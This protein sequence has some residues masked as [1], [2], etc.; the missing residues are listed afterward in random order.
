MVLAIMGLL[1]GGFLL[2]FGTWLDN[3]RVKDT[4]R[5]L[6]AVQEAL[7]GFAITA[8]VPRLPCPDTD[9]DGLED[10]A[11]DGSCLQTEGALPW[12]SLGLTR[13][14][15][16]GRPFRYAPDDAYAAA[17]GIPARP[18]T[19]TGFVVQDS[20]GVALTDRT[21]ASPPGPPPNGPA[22]IVFS[23]GPN[24]RPDLEND[25]DGAANTDAFCTNPGTSDGLYTA[26]TR[27]EGLFDDRLFWLSRNILLN[28]LVAAGAWP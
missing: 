25:N 1:L 3:K 22:A 24:G 23:C 27:R 18:D 8:I 15:A 28:R 13:E 5:R 9:G 26:N 7:V 17:G 11:A 12:A 6:A 2:P 14:D 4:E 16:W 21:P 10:R 20:A 19:L